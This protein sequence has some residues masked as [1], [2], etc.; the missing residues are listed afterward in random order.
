[1]EKVT[2]KGR[3]REFDT[4]EALAAALKV[5]WAKGYEAASLS[6]LTEAMG[7]TR[8]SLYAAFG[9]KEAL[10]RKA[11]DLY[12]EEKQAYVAKALVAETARGVASN[13]LYG[14]IE[15]VA[16]DECKGC[17]GVMSSVGCQ[18][19]V[20][21]IRDDVSRRS[22]SSRRAL[23]ARMQQAIADGDFSMPVEAEA[24]ANYLIAVIQGL[25]VQA[26]SGTERAQLE[27]VAEAALAIW[28]SR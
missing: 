12:E 22:E 16:G 11:F 23:I 27:N 1:M 14:A 18:S 20:E 9:N 21:S 15:T 4:E 8:P 13:L 7:I 25:A 3:P 24:I 26:S 17:L 5:F 19:A 10:F 2:T 28:P 6:D